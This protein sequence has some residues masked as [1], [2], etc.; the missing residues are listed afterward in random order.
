MNLNW[1]FFVVL[2]IF[3]LC[4]ILGWK[5]GFVRIVF[6]L[7]ATVIALILTLI[8]CPITINVLKSQG[9]VYDKIYKGVDSFIDLDE[10]YKK[11]AASDD[12]DKQTL[13]EKLDTM[14]ENIGLPS[15]IR[16]SVVESDIVQNLSGEKGEEF[17]KNELA[18]LETVIC[19]NLTAT[20]INALG[21][22]ITLLI[23][24]IVLFILGKTLDLLAKL[25]LLKQ[26]N[27]W[28]GILVGAAEGLLLVW[29][30]FTVVTMFAATPF[31]QNMLGMITENGFLQFLYDKNVIALKFFS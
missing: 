30:F 2:A 25:P 28:L 31:G 16:K 5:R 22:I 24:I 21:F 20:T 15:I 1:L 17:Q 3:A 19:E 26:V 9:G 12:A 4:I 23:V 29:I 6:S 13:E 8:L 18:K 10:A 27:A 7:A 11:V 14:M